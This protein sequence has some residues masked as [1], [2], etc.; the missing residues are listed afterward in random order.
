MLSCK[1]DLPQLSQGT[2]MSFQNNLYNLTLKQ[3]MLDIFLIFQNT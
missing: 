2:F 3:S 1:E